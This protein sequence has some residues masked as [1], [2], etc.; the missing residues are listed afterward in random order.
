M[1]ALRTAQ[2]SRREGGSSRRSQRGVPFGPLLGLPPERS[3]IVWF[4]AGAGASDTS[5]G[6]DWHGWSGGRDRHTRD[7]LSGASLATWLAARSS[8][9]RKHNIKHFVH[10][11]H[12]REVHALA[13]I[14]SQLIEVFQV[15]ARQD[16]HAYPRAMRRQRLLFHATDR[17]H[18]TTQGN[19]ASYRHVAA[20]KPSGER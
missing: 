8:S 12:R 19:L 10:R 1:S 18:A 4:P 11:L 16:H 20:H 2:S 5:G 7:T 14:R 9:R 15:A 17:K 6:R 13:H 3:R